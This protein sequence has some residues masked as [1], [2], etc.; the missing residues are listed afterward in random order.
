LGAKTSSFRS[1]AQIFNLS[2]I[3]TATRTLLA[4]GVK[5]VIGIGRV[6]TPTLAIVCSREIEIRLLRD[7]GHRQCR[8]WHTF[9][10]RHAPPA[11]A[12]IRD[13]AVA[14][15]I[16]KPPPSTPAHWPCRSSIAGRRRRA[17]SIYRCCR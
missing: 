9:L 16:A 10:M 3:R 11:K 2:L 8:G 15:A 13:R 14:E 17:C 4:R 7:R 6:K 5:G 1:A 12:R